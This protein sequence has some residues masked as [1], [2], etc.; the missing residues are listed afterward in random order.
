MY[1]YDKA[2]ELAALIKQSDEFTKY[3]QLKDKI[4]EDETT[5]SLVKEYKKLQFEAQASYMTGKQPD[6]ELIDK[7]NKMGE[8][9]QFNNEVTEYFAAEY[10]LNTLIGDIYKILGDACDV[11][12]D[13]M[14]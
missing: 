5:K 10:K 8:V 14:D 9:L 3:K 11:G 12:L 13:F 7:I 2:N 6:N 1:I 4:Y